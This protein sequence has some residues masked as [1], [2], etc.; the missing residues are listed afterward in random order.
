ME[1]GIRKHLFK[2][3]LMPWITKEQAL[4]AGKG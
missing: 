2:L 3:G 1:G 4:D